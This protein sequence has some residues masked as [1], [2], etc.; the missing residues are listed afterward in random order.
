M[1]EGI[2]F[3]DF[4]TLTGQLAEIPDKTRRELRPWLKKG[5]AL[6]VSS[7]GK[8]K[9]MV[10]ATPPFQLGAKGKDANQSAA[11]GYGENKVG[12][13][14]WRVYG[15]PSQAYQ[16]IVAAS[17]VGAAKGFWDA[18]KANDIT[19]AS[20]ILQKAEGK[21]LEPFDD[22]AEHKNRRVDGQ[23]EGRRQTFF[24]TKKEWINAYV[25]EKKKLVGLL[26]SVLLQP[27]LK[28]FS[29]F[30]KLP[31]FV[32]RHRLSGGTID[33]HEDELGESYYFSISTFYAI[34]L[35]RLI[36]SV[37]KF[38]VFAME[39]ELPTVIKKMNLLPP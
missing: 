25:K 37:V 15:G 32:D 17:G 21:R 28:E 27:G 1:S 24:T 12:S 35:Q 8:Y 30:P 2:I 34:D 13:Q 22:G 23:V 19:K 14:I 7:S 16:R 20:D 26:C 39:N 11:K 3:F 9:G 29:A 10:Q 33:K 31:V 18:F 36:R 38:R 4:L 6:V 5:A